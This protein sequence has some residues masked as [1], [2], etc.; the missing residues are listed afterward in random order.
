MSD[1]ASPEAGPRVFAFPKG[2]YERLLEIRGDQNNGGDWS[3]PS[4]DGFDISILKKGEGKK[5]EYTVVACRDSSALGH[6]EWLDQLDVLPPLVTLFGKVPTDDEVREKLGGF[7]LGMMGS[8][9][10][11]A[12]RGRT[13]GGGGNAGRPRKTAMDDARQVGDED[14]H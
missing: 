2:V 5:T 9:P 1:R 12:Q 8:A 11:V 4:E 6:D 10:S 13:A 7:D 14:K 3:D